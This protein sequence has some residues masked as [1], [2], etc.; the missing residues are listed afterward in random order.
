[1][2]F[3]LRNIG[4]LLKDTREEKGL[5]LDQVSN[6]LFIKKRVIVAIESG[7]WAS[8]P[9]PVYVKGYVNQYATLLDIAGPV[10]AG[11]ISPEKQ[12][13]PE[14][15]G[16]AAALK[17]EGARKRW[18]LKSEGVSKGWGR[19]KKVVVISALGVLLV[20]FLVFQN[21]HKKAYVAPPAQRAESSHQTVQPSSETQPLETSTPSQPVEANPVTAKQSQ[22]LV[23]APKKLTITC[24]ERTWVK[25]VIDGAEQKEFMLN[26]EEVVTLNAQKNF[27]L[28]IG[29]A[30][31]VKLIFNGKDTGFT[32]EDGEVKHISLS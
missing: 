32:G 15:Q 1:M 27:D 2:P 25:I 14:L 4:E 26:P 30:G 7:D 29:N 3:D 22:N 24:Q 28:L 23:L 17:T 16:V 8:L 13:S 18:A 9:Y 12:P 31:G 20:G 5:T 21:L 19:A 10:E 11:M 6:A